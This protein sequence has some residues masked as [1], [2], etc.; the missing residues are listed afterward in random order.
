[1]TI[2]KQ[3]TAEAGVANGTAVDATNSALAGDAVLASAGSAGS[4]I[5]SNTSPYRGMLYYEVVPSGASG[6]RLI[7]LSG[8]S[9]DNAGTFRSTFAYKI[10][11]LPAGTRDVVLAYNTVGISTRMRLAATGIPSFMDRAGSTMFTG[12]TAL[13]PNRWYIVKMVYTTGTSTTT[14]RVI[15]EVTDTTTSTV[16]ASYSS[17]AANTG[18]AGTE[19]ASNIQIGKGTTSTDTFKTGVD[20][21]Q[22]RT[23]GVH[24]LLDPL[25][26]PVITPVVWMDTTGSGNW[27]GY[28]MWMDTSGAGAWAR[29]DL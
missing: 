6:Q 4:L 7:G 25:T 28:E 20:D 15:W 18:V 17:D 21:L 10:D 5:F 16:I 3:N 9:T 22:A 2:I 13:V 1:M 26:T 12:T 19:Y 14:G 27:K 11:S 29:Y 24:A 8:F 23:D